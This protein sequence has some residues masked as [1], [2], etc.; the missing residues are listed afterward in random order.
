MPGP[1]GQPDS[2]GLCWVNS[3]LF[4][5]ILLVKGKWHSLPPHPPPNCN[6]FP[7]S[8][9]SSNFAHLQVSNQKLE[10]VSPKLCILYSYGTGHWLPYSIAFGSYFEDKDSLWVGFPAPSSASCTWRKPFTLKL[11]V[12]VFGP[13]SPLESWPS[14][15]FVYFCWPIPVARNAPSTGWWLIEHHPSGRQ[16]SSQLL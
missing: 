16:V 13:C 10:L 15:W 2:M 9:P 14:S 11:W 4:L 7:S 5:I 12:T 8:Y 3:Y 6:V 1:G